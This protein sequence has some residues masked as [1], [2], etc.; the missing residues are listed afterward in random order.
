MKKAVISLVVLAALSA[1]GFYGW[2]HLPTHATDAASEVLRLSTA[3]AELRDIQLNVSAAG[4]IGPADQVSVRP[5]VNGKIATLPVDIGDKV[6]KGAPLF[7]LDDSDLQIERSSQLSQI[8]GAKLQL[9]KAERNFERSKKLFA[10]NLV[11]RETYDDTVTEF[12]LAKNT[13]ERAEKDLKLVEDRISKT[14]ISAPF[15]CTVL[16]RPVSIGQAV[17]GS[18]GYNSGTEVLTIA[19]LQDM[20]VMAH[21]NQSDVARLARGQHVDISV[22]S[23]AGLKM[24]GEIERIAPQATLKNNLKGY[25]IRISIKT[26]D[27]RARPGMTSTLSIPVSSAKGT[28]SIPLAAVFSE[29][30]IDTMEMERYVYIKVDES[31]YERRPIE[32]GL[33]DNN[34]AEVIKGLKEGDVVSM[35]IPPADADIKVLDDSAKKEKTVAAI[36]NRSSSVSVH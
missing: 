4:D 31:T 13:L 9:Q 22:E 24:A 3:K 14:K 16:T 19:N 17:S 27:P 30:N 32:V 8:E 10:D 33:T 36:T 1:G 7:S 29:P 25:D 26:I 5:E 12:E 21:I 34:Y 2:K 6:K 23:V 28:L 15:D 35:E 20:I 18:G 11:S